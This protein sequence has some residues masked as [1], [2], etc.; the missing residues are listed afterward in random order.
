MQVL[1]P[2]RI[3]SLNAIQVLLPQLLTVATSMDL[4]PNFSR[5]VVAI[6]EAGDLEA[7]AMSTPLSLRAY[8][9][10]KACGYTGGVS[11]L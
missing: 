5:N 2:R 7:T 11:S 4:M 10:P 9:M 6:S 3:I 8:N 1:A